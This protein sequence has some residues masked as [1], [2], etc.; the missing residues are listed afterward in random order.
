MGWTEL[1]NQRTRSSRHYQDDAD[2]GRRICSATIAPL[3]YESILD[4]G[5][6][7]LPLDLSPL[8]I[9]NAQL[10]GWRVTHAGWHYALG[11]PADKITD[12]WVGF[13]GRKGAHWF[14][15]RLTRVGYLHG[16]T[17]SWDDV[18]G[19]PDY[20]RAN[21][22]HELGITDIG[23]NNE[24]LTLTSA[25]TWSHI[26]TTPGGG[27]LDLQWRINGDRLK[28]N[29][30]I[31]QAAR[32]WIQSNRPPATPLN[33]T[34][35]G[36]VFQVDWSDVPRALLGDV[37]QDIDGDFDDDLD[38][39]TLRDASDR[40]LAL[41]PWSYVSVHDPSTNLP[42]SHPLRKRFWKD[43]DGNH[44]MLLG[45]RCDRLAGMPAGPLH[46]DP[47]VDAQVGA[48]A[49]DGIAAGTPCTSH[50][51]S[52]AYIMCGDWAG[53]DRAS[54][55]RFTG[56]TI[57]GTITTSYLQ[58]YEYTGSS[59]GTPTLNVYGVDE[60]NPAAPTNCAEW[61]TDYGLH[62]SASVTWDGVW[63]GTWNNSP[64]L[65]AIFQELVNSYVISGDAVMLQIC[66][67]GSPASEY[68][69]AYDYTTSSANAAKLHIEYTS[70][71]G[72]FIGL[73]GALFGFLSAVA[74]V[75]TNTAPFHHYKMRRR[76]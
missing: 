54:W 31:N 32:E 5:V 69:A 2:P 30:I 17:R 18:G 35:F 11:Q 37:L 45:V 46:F 39:V 8:P 1:T 21:L 75:V 27:R 40:L 15:F 7:D 16:P 33:E 56:I 25:S 57:S 6:Y 66:N 72:G 29:V 41:L 60:D 65:N 67:D 73:A 63:S 48:D 42:I 10:D 71:D 49:D 64:S 50:L 20:D 4:S 12:G 53:D 13:G 44:Y 19:A 51:P 22:S 23:P 62:T 24:P 68:N 3:H 38:E 58:V 34:Y 26:W 55:V 47:T 14:K 52:N 43:P 9:N 76:N 59:T 61:D 28:E 36:F 74:W 70:A